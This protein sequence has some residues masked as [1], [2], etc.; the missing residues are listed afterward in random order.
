MESQSEEFTDRIHWHSLPIEEVYEK[1]CTSPAGLSE[2]EAGQR[3]IQYGKNELPE[4]S[5]PA[6]HSSFSASLKVPSFIF[7][8]LRRL[9]HFFSMI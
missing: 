9:F 3:F 5:R 7:S 1:L 6:R 8:L 4:K 2:E